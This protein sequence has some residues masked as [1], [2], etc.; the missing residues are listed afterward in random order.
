MQRQ[1][2]HGPVTADARGAVNRWLSPLAAGLMALHAALLALVVP[3]IALLVI[4]SLWEGGDEARKHRLQVWAPF[5]VL[6]NVAGAVLLT[7]GAVAL[8]RRPP[9]ALPRGTALLLAALAAGWAFVYQS[10]LLHD[11]GTLALW[12][13]WTVP[14]LV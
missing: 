8:A 1:Q 2:S 12:L 5:A 10:E 4:G 14:G 7:L 13:A 9:A 3:V 11:G 6:G